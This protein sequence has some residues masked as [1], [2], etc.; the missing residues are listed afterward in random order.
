MRPL[1]VPAELSGAEL[2]SE[3][4]SLGPDLTPPAKRVSDLQSQ[5]N[6]PST[7]TF[8]RFLN[9]CLRSFLPCRLDFFF[10][11]VGENASLLVE[12][13]IEVLF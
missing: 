3:P 9:L 10:P 13:G 1:S 4:T 12:A 8:D 2:T 7:S 5:I 11:S 6:V